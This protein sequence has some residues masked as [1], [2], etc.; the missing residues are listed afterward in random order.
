MAFEFAR[1]GPRKSRKSPWNSHLG[2]NGNPDER[3]KRNI[4]QSS[5]RAVFI[6]PCD[7]TSEPNANRVPAVLI[8]SANTPEVLI[9]SANTPEV[10][11]GSENTQRTGVSSDWVLERVHLMGVFWFKFWFVRRIR[12]CTQFMQS[13][14]PTD[15][16]RA[17][18]VCKSFVTG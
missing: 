2:N 5:Y 18:T 12:F 14:V 7:E 8:G 17:A 9:G 11:I 6:Q 13:C 1:D 4:V 15:C 3:C 10:L 16:E